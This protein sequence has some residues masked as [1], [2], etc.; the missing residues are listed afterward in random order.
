MKDIQLLEIV[1]RALAEDIG[2]GDVTT[3][4]IVPADMCLTGR[5]IAKQEGIV[6]GLT[7]ARLTFAALDKCIKFEAL[8]ADGDVVKPSQT[9]ATLEGPVCA[10]LRG[11]RVALNFMQRMSGIATATRHYV[12]TIAGSGATMLDTRKTVP[13]LRWLDKWAVRIGGGAN[14]RMGLDD[15]ALIKENH[16]AAAGGSITEAVRRIRCNDPHNR[17]IEVE[18]KNLTELEETLALN[19][20]RIMLDNMSLAEMRRAVQ[21]ANNRT[22][23]E[24]SGNITLD[25]VADVAATGV[26]YIS[27]GSLTHSVQAFDIS[28]LLSNFICIQE[29]M[30]SSWTENTPTNT[31]A[32][33]SF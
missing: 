24:A 2:T 25:T 14:H 22:P 21:M 15:M 26:D 19:V 4:C 31:V 8:V 11:E 13:G 20:D 33:L 12:D 9:I 23:L 5:F 32:N 27:S 18:V 17:P 7:I 16:I 28:L 6:A 1:S 10:I 30:D 3:D 29:Q